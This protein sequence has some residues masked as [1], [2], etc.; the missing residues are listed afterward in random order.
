[1][2]TEQERSTC[3]ESIL[4]VYE[5]KV[6]TVR[7]S[8]RYPHIDFDDAYA[9]SG[10]VARRQQAAGSKL[11]GYKVGL[12]SIAMRRSSKIDEPDYGYLYEEFLFH[13]GAKIPH[14]LFCVP[15]VELELAFVLG[16]SLKGPGVS[17]MDVLD[18]TD[19]VVPSME[20][21]DTRV[22]EPRQI[23]DTIADNGAGAGLVLGGRAVRP[24]QVDLTMIPGIL[25]RN[26][27]IE[28]TGVSCGVMGNPV[29]GIVWLANKLAQIGEELHPGQILLAGSYVRPIW[30]QVGDVVRADFGDL[31]AITVQFV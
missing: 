11:V 12:T 1:M 26:A 5:T 2:L 22:D 6:Q 17:M 28:E 8:A 13:D 24:N 23:Y 10:E 20:I 30:A 15:R 25:S 27:D 4:E 19:Y 9:I 29:N 3:V 16:K 14:A 7:P 31:G 18:A 21:I